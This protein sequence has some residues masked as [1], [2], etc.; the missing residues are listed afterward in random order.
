MKPKTVKNTFIYQSGE[1]VVDLA[2][3]DENTWKKI[4]SDC[5]LI[6]LQKQ[7]DNVGVAYIAAFL[8]YLYELDLL[9]EP[10]DSTIHKFH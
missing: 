2:D 10:F 5:R 3:I 9:S 8:L 6:M 4:Q 7:T 1:I